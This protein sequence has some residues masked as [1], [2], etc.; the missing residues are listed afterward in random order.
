MND[1][2]RGNPKKRFLWRRL[3]PRLEHA[4]EEE[5]D[6]CSSSNDEGHPQMKITRHEKKH[7]KKSNEI[8]I[9]SP[10]ISPPFSE[11]EEEDAHSR[12]IESTSSIK[13]KPQPMRAKCELPEHLQGE[14]SEEEL[15]C[16]PA[17]ER[18]LVER[19]M[20]SFPRPFL[21]SIDFPMNNLRASMLSQSS[22]ASLSLESP[23]TN[24]SE[25][26]SCNEQDVEDIE[27]EMDTEAKIKNTRLVLSTAASVLLLMR[28]SVTEQ[29]LGTLTRGG[30]K[31]TTEDTK[32]SEETM[33]R[34]VTVK[35]DSRPVQP[36]CSLHIVSP[37]T[38]NKPCIIRVVSMPEDATPACPNR[39]A[40]PEDPNELN[41]LHCFVRAHLLEIFSLPPQKEKPGRVG[42]RCVFC[43]HLPRKDRSGTTMCTFYPKSL[44]DLY[45]SVMT[46]QRIHFRSCKHVSPKMKDEYWKHKESD[47]TRGKTTYWVT[48]AMRLGLQD[49]NNGRNGICFVNPLPH[50]RSN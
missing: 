16:E 31:S 1:I 9:A 48:S 11:E 15:S 19:S 44:Q 26:K 17:E 25:E 36:T 23:A 43:F 2:R 32:S 39:L 18:K 21:A 10:V 4:E 47:Q 20:L 14:S 38:A 40:M 50:A 13:K 41:S 45:R 28:F 33:A 35:P 27:T 22:A 49:I 8:H 5:Y 6:H 29:A 24:K 46:W 3:L 12:A 42:L 7:E 34:G 30:R 37:E